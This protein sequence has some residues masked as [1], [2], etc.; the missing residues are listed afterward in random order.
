MLSSYNPSKGLGQVRSAK[1]QCIV[2]YGKKMNKSTTFNVG[3]CMTRNISSGPTNFWCNSK[4]PPTNLP[5]MKQEKNIVSFQRDKMTWTIYQSGVSI[6]GEERLVS[7][8]PLCHG[9]GFHHIICSQENVCFCTQKKS[10]T[11]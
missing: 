9:Y 1:M 8:L 6:K 11:G 4:V 3:S 10:N 7:M 2:H 5:P